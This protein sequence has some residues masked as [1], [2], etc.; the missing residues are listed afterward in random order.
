M[1]GDVIYEDDKRGPTYNF[2]ELLGTIINAPYEI[3]GYVKGKIRSMLERGRLE[4]E[5]EKDL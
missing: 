5:L 4:E 1:S 3:C 2:F